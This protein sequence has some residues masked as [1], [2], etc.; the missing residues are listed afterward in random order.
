MTTEA[1]DIV[2]VGAGVAG[3]A[4]SVSAA[5]RGASVAMVERRQGL[6]GVAT[7]GMVGTICGISRCGRHLSSSPSYDNPGFA[8]EFSQRVALRSGKSLLRNALGLSYLPYI[9]AAFEAVSRVIVAEHASLVRHIPEAS[10]RAMTRSETTNEISV[11]LSTPTHNE[12]EIRA[13]ALI[14]CSGD[15]A[16]LRLLSIATTPPAP[17]QA[18]ALVFELG[19]LPDTDEQMLSFSVRK[20]LREAVLE[21][22]LPEALSYVSLVPGSLNEQRALFKLGVP[23]PSI[24]ATGGTCE[25]STS[26]RYGGALAALPR[27]LAC[28]QARGAGLASTV[29]TLSAP[30]LGV[31]SGSRGI[32]QEEL[33]SQAV[34]LSERHTNGIALGL[35]PVELWE[36]P[37]KPRMVFPERGEGY[38]IPVGS[39]CARG[40]DG[41]YFAG[42]T[43]AATDYAI[44]SARVIGTSLS[45]GYAA[46]WFAAARLKGHSV[47]DIVRAIRSEQVEPWYCANNSAD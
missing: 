8:T 14:D 11:C 29:H 44:G 7:S 47:N 38:E 23:S 40:V 15:S 43:I 21:G 6:G 32:G 19:Q 30:A 24:D 41:I 31:R 33:S 25:Q 36:S 35:W 3:I 46:G 9:P 42:R 39:L 18:A 5:R 45:T 27:I 2:V 22:E 34:R 16:A 17:P 12:F 1:F 10:L 13:R 4:A 26:E 20:A 28:I 37:A